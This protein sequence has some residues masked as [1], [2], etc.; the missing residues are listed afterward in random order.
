MAASPQNKPRHNAK[1]IAK[2]GAKNHSDGDFIIKEL[3]TQ[4]VEARNQPNPA[5]Q[6]ICPALDQELALK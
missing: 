6:R 5:D 4:K 2:N 1:E 3:D